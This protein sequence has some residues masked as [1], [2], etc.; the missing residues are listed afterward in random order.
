MRSGQHM[1]LHSIAAKNISTNPKWL[2]CRHGLFTW[3]VCLTFTLL[4][5]SPAERIKLHDNA[6]TKPH[7]HQRHAVWLY[8]CKSVVGKP[9]PG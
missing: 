9:T 1:L 5:S 4:V 6:R 2:N 3:Q 8:I 7:P